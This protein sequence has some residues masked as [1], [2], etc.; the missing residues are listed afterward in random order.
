MVESVF[1]IC[2][3]YMASFKQSLVNYVFGPYIFR[4]CSIVDNIRTCAPEDRL[5]AYTNGGEQ[6]YN[7]IADLKFLPIEVHFKK[8]SMATILSFKTVET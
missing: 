3:K 6:V 2:R 8:S 1:K 4:L 7:L 5:T